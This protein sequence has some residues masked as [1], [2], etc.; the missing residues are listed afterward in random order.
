MQVYYF[1]TISNESSWTKPEGFSG[2]VW[3]AKPTSQLRVPGTAWYEIHCEDGRKYYYND[4]TEV[5]LQCFSKYWPRF[6]GLLNI[7]FKAFQR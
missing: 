6:S 4:Q 5:D 1:N 2:E 7:S 3:D